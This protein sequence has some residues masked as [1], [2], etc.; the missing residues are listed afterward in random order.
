MT[1]KLFCMTYYQIMSRTGKKLQFQYVGK[2]MQIV[3][4]L[5]GG[6]IS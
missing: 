5:K 4:V 2:L 1:R 3:K 6:E